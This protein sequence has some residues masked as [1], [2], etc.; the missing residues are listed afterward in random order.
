MKLR[1]KKEWNYNGTL[2]PVG[3]I[4]NVD[5]D[6]AKDMIGR[7]LAEEYEPQAGDV[8]RPVAM[9]APENIAIRREELQEMIEEIVRRN[10]SQFQQNSGR[11]EDV[12]EKTGGYRSF[13]EFA[14]DVYLASIRKGQMPERLRNWM[15]YCA[16]QQEN[17][18]LGETVGSDG[19]YLVPTEF[20]AQLMSAVL[21][22][23]IFLNRVVNV[24]MATNTI[25]IPT[26]DESDRS[27][28]VY[29]G[30]V[31]YRVGEGETINDSGPKFGTVT[32]KL[33]KVAALCKVSS[34]LLEDSPISLEP[35]LND[36][37]AKALARQIDDDIINGDGVGKPLGILKAPAT[38]T[39]SKESG[40][41]A[42]SIVTENILKMWSR[43]LSAGDAI[44]LANKD[45]YPQLATLRLPTGT[46][47]TIAA[48][49]VG[50]YTNG[51]T[52]QP[53][54]T[55]QG[56]PLILTELCQTLGTKGDLILCSPSWILFGEKSGGG[57]R[58]AS[59]IHLAFAEDKIAFRYIVRYDAQPWIKGAIKPKYSTNTLSPFVVLQTR[60]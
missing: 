33:N 40:Q 6:N 3:F 28:S 35:I 18:A 9:S 7:G 25:D 17:R 16:K 60:S 50:Q 58:T 27:N 39:V 21:E 4:V 26:V 52:G 19:G 56:A 23:S 15:A 53:E 43:L 22:E 31:V 46:S 32:L 8:A 55:L 38:V 45:T 11:N 47:T 48:G 12:F 51:L 41:A 24:P 49:L 44:W 54:M 34:E 20:R 10:A 13:G 29:G 1:L 59:S 37:F 42:A 57:I 36:M 5:D 30:V 14:R 2:L